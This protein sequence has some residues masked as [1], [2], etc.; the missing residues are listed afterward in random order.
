[1]FIINIDDA[2]H[3]AALLG[4]GAAPEASRLSSPY[5]LSLRAAELRLAASRPEVVEKDEKPTIQPKEKSG[6]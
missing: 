6:K 4:K 3:F 1:M 2:R 5:S